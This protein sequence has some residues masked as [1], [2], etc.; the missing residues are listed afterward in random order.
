MSVR[1]VLLI[2]IFAVSVNFFL[3]IGLRR[4]EGHYYMA[5]SFSLATLSHLSSAHYIPPLG[6]SNFPT[7]DVNYQSINRFVLV[8]LFCNI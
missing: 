6:R 8:S 3:R 2:R 4:K 5:T 1:G 7:R